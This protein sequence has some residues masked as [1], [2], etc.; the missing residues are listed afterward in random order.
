MQDSFLLP[1]YE[2]RGESGKPSGVR[3]VNKIPLMIFLAIMA[4]FVVLMA[5]VAT[6]RSTERFSKKNANQD[7]TVQS[8]ENF[9]NQVA[10]DHHL[11][12][13]IPPKETRK[14]I[15]DPLIPSNIIIERPK[16]LDLPPSPPGN[17]SML[18]AK[19]PDRG[20]IKMLK[21]QQLE[22]AI[23]AKT[24][25]NINSPRNL[26]NTGGIAA[27]E[28]KSHRN[29]ASRSG[30]GA[31]A[32]SYQN[33]LTELKKIGLNG[34]NPNI[35]EAMMLVGD[36]EEQSVN[37]DYAQYDTHNHKTRWNLKSGVEKPKSRYIVQTG[38]VIPAV[39]ITGINSDLPG[40]ITAQV[41][42]HVYDTPVGKHLL[43][44]QGSRLIGAYHHEVVY[45]QERVL[46]A[47]QRIVFPDGKTMDIGAMPGTDSM[48]YAGFKDQVDHH[49]MRI[50]GSALI[51]SA[52]IAGATYSQRDSGGA[53]G[54]QNAGSILSQSLGQQLGMVTANLIRRNLN[55]SPTIAIRPGYRFNV[56]VT[57]DMVF[58]RPYQ[59]FDYSLTAH[60]Q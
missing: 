30:S 43:I 51:M 37:N 23:K 59:S 1:E 44:P 11:K 52:I 46:I 8:T 41:S 9:A 28:Q 10:R 50:F 40:Q 58:N 42:Q 39:L 5:I 4:V 57:K 17:I 33:K 31:S 53:F 35:D 20:H 55:I 36:E 13:I 60:R 18:S 21:R 12:G 27:V 29:N 3:R 15:N 2:P 14:A 34:T 38:F 24:Q 54:R 48:G 25:V 45:G 22:D 19:D 7:K 56:F 49:Y 32:S 6:N 26:Q 47:W 16:N